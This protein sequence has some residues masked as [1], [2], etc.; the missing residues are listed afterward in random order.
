MS[1]R[2]SVTGSKHPNFISCWMLDKPSISDELVE[3]FENNKKFQSPGFVTGGRVDEKV[4]NSIDLTISPYQL[5]EKKFRAAARY[6]EEL[7]ALYSDYLE[8]WEFLKSFL[9]RAHIGPFNIQKYNEGGHFGKLH[10]ER[11]SLNSLQRT[12]VW[13]TYLNDVEDGG[14]T[15]FP[16]F[17]LKVKPEKGKTLIWPAEWTHAH[18]GSVVTRG[19]KYIITGWL[20]VPDD[21]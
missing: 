20:H 6:M 21:V 13:M 18:R 10:S 3:L 7:K 14:E 8:Q 16:M 17:G 1:E 4:K 12:L 15:E 9:P 19:T 11:T 2:Q 5:E